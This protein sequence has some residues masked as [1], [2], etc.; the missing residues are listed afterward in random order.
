MK[1][2]L[3][4]RLAL[5][6][7]LAFPALAWSNVGTSSALAEL[8]QRVQQ[9]QL[10]SVFGAPIFV[11]SNG[12][13][14]RLAAEAFGLVDHAF[15]G[16]ADGLSS[17]A[18]WCQ[19]MPLNFNIKACTYHTE[20]NQT[21]LTFYAGRKFYEAPDDVYQLHYRYRII[22]R[23]DDYVH[24]LLS[25]EEGPMGTRD[26]RIELE[27]M[28][29]GE[30]SFIRIRSSYRSSFISRLAT[31]AYLA[32]LGRDKVGFS[33][34]GDT[35]SGEPVYVGGVDGVIERNAMRY[36]LALKAF[37]DTTGLSADER[38]EARI[39]SWFDMNEAHAI[40]LHELERE[41]YLDAKRRER[42]NQIKLQQRLAATGKLL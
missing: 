24:M 17:P 12:E 13:G 42:H 33:V 35:D 21:R 27:A 25:A 20:D 31:D 29:A 34:T 16:L 26:Y 22:S 11:R 23:S 38:F 9:G 36:Y 7:C 41:E 19:V 3:F 10:R 32:T 18:N 15:S 40:Q 37:L 2:H 5:A 6:A 14:E 30:K 4:W 28:P 1:F 8:Y 39:R